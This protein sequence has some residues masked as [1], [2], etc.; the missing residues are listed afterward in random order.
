MG[1]KSQS[2]WWWTTWGLIFHWLCCLCCLRI[3]NY[4][5]HLINRDHVSRVESFDSFF[6]GLERS[7]LFGIHPLRSWKNPVVCSHL[8]P[9]G[10]ERSQM[11]SIF[12]TFGGWSWKQTFT[13]VFVRGLEKSLRL[14]IFGHGPMTFWG[15]VLKMTKIYFSA[16][17]VMVCHSIFSQW[18]WKELLELVFSVVSM[19]EMDLDIHSRITHEWDLTWHSLGVLWWSLFESWSLHHEI[20]GL[21][22]NFLS[23]AELLAWWTAMVYQPPVIVT[24][25][26]NLGSLQESMFGLPILI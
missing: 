16:S 2:F 11:W 5:T 10:L 19:A 13:C 7:Q 8:W 9:W 21:E 24:F 12:A 15:M 18:S 20:Y 22:R 6:K 26:S 17:S 3:W 25:K 14:C 4:L 23:S 1:L